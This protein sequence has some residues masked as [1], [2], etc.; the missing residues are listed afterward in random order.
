MAAFDHHTSRELDPQPHTHV[1]ILNLA[2]RKDGTWGA[3]LSRELYRAQKRAGATYRMALASEL[4]RADHTI[5]YGIE[6]FR[7]AAIPRGIERLFS[8]RRQAIEAAAAARGYRTA[9]GMELAALRT[10]KAK[11]AAPREALFEI[12]QADARALG[13]ELKRLNHQNTRA[14]RAGKAGPRIGGDLHASA[15]SKS[16]NATGARRDCA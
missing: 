16:E 1:F 12:W 5:D 7:V 11:R 13:Y 14:P 10:R 2:P 4:E 9:K 3:L 15:A 6:N 8:K